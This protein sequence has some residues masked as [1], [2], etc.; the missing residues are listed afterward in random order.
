MSYDFIG[1]QTVEHSLVNMRG[2]F[3][4]EEK[5]QSY[6]FAGDTEFNLFPKPVWNWWVFGK[7]MQLCVH[8]PYNA[9][10][11]RRIISTIILGSEW[12]KL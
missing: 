3:M 2:S 5:E 1:V 10:L 4:A 7:K 12:E 11:Y 8:L 6:N 9:P